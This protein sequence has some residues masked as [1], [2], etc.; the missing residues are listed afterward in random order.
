MLPDYLGDRITKALESSKGNK[1]LLNLRFSNK[2]KVKFSG[3]I[4][5][6]MMYEYDIKTLEQH[7][8]LKMFIEL[9]RFC[10]KGYLETNARLERQHEHACKLWEAF[11]GKRRV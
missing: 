8:E 11:K 1:V 7:K 5:D 4:I 10:A 2:G 3:I 9:M 6:D